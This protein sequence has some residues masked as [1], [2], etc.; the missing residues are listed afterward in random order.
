MAMLSRD[1]KPENILL[2]SRDND[3]DLKLADFGF[4]VNASSIALGTQQITVGTPGYISPEVIS[5]KPHGPPVDMWAMGVVLYMLL[6][7]YPPFYEPEDSR[8]A[9]FNR[10]LA[11]S[12]EFHPENW[13]EVSDEAKDL[14]R[15][16]LVVDPTQRLAVNQA[17]AHPWIHKPS[18]ELALIRLERNLVLLKDWRAQRARHAAAVAN[19]AIDAMR[20]LSAANVRGASIN[21]VAIDVMRKLSGTNLNE[22]VVEAARRKSGLHL[23]SIKDLKATADRIEASRTRSGATVAAMAKVSSNANLAAP[24]NS[25]DPGQW[26]GGAATERRRA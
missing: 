18:T 14:I 7:G 25:T 26:N 23:G 19:I 20:K 13:A 16:L 8:Q 15:Q 24:G 5:R 4:C 9:V 2:V 6:G 10:I 22:A 12:Y 21:E 1:I 11:A 17:L 3:V